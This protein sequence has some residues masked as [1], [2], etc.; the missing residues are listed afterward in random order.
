MSKDIRCYDYVNHPY[1]QVRD[2]LKTDALAVFRAAT[3]AATS[4]AESVAA[5]LRLDLG[6]IAIG[7][8]IAISV[9]GIGENVD[10]PSTSIRLE[11][12]AAKLPG[13]F[14][15]MK[16]EL[17]IYPLTRTETQLDF[18]G[19]YEPPMGALGGVLNAVAG[20]RIADVSV[21]RFVSEVAAHLR[22]TLEG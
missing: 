14:P 15:L 21:H 11:W 16:A 5:E 19:T 6:G 18:S 7:T 20:H 10:G 8:D 1:E 2:A 9:T 4:R 3:K 22:R 17:Q 13:L 12:E